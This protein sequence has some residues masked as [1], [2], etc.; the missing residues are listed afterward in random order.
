MANL[1]RFNNDFNNSPKMILN[2]S[3]TYPNV[4]T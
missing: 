3:E 1:N 4:T 2:N